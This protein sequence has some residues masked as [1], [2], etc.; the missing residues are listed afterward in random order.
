MPL[1]RACTGMTLEFELRADKPDRR[2]RRAV[3]Q[4]A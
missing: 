1:R 2:R 4:G 3:A